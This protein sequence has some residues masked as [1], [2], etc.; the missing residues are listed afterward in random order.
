MLSLPIH[1]GVDEAGYGPML[2][3]LVVGCAA[4]ASDNPE[5]ELWN[6]LADAV[7]LSPQNWDG[8]VVQ[9]SKLLFRKNSGIRRLEEGCL[10][11]VASATGRRPRTLGELLQAL[12][13]PCLTGRYPWYDIAA[14]LPR[15]FRQS[16]SSAA[17]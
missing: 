17:L 12:G 10:A 14:A 1:A 16:R 2:G 8:L 11:F 4:M 13:A 9:D 7:R 6:A 3:P 15:Y 5:T